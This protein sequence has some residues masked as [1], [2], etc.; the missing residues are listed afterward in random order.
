MTALGSAVGHN[1]RIGSGL[2]V[3]PARMIESDVI[4]FA[5]PDR[6]VIA[7]NVYYEDSD[8]LKIEGGERLH[9][10]YYPRD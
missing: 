2:I 6:R 7:K 1:V 9:P 10:R 5:S 3:Y 4:L 8:H